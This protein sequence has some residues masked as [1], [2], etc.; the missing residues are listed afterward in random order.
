IVLTAPASVVHERKREVSLAE[1][2]RQQEAYAALAKRL[3]NAHL[4]D[5]G[6]AREVVANDVL[7][8]ILTHM[9]ER[10]LRRSKID[11]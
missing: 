10:T 9:H 7:D 3:P 2:E 5:A 8:I 4:V 6:R 1:T 11:A